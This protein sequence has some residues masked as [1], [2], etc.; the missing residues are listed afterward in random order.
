MALVWFILLV[1][2]TG[3][4]NAEDQE[5]AI[6]IHG[7]AGTLE[8]VK[9]DPDKASQYRRFLGELVSDGHKQLTEGHPGLDVV[10]NI[11]QKN[12]RLS[13]V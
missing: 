11:I 9:M 6:A 2:V 1:L 7:G 5:V 12:G 13:A 4:A 8:R 10:V 3:V